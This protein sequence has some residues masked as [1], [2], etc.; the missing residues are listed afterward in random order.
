V[1]ANVAS[2]RLVFD[3]EKWIKLAQRSAE[4]A[5]LDSFY[6][7]Q[8]NQEGWAFFEANSSSYNI[9]LGASTDASGSLVNNSQIDVRLTRDGFEKKVMPTVEQLSKILP[10]LSLLQPE[11]QTLVDFFVR[12]LSR[13]GE[14]YA[15]AY[16]NFFSSL[17]LRILSRE[18]LIMYLRE[19]QRPGSAFTQNLVRIKENVIL[20]IPEGPNYQPFRERLDDFR[21][22]QT[23]MQEDKGTYPQLQRYMTII[24]DLSDKLAGNTKPKPSVAGGE[25]PETTSSG[26]R[27]L[28]SPMGRVTYDLKLAGDDNNLVM[29]QSWLREMMVP[30]QWKR[31]FLAPILKL[32]EYG[33]TEINSAVA[34]LWSKL[35]E[36][37]VEP[38]LGLFPFDLTM[39]R[40]EATPDMIGEVLHPLT[41]TFWR[42]FHNHFGGILDITEG[43]LAIR[44]DFRDFVAIPAKTQYQMDAVQKFTNT[45]WNKEGK[46]EPIKLQ[47]K[48][49]LLPA[50]PNREENPDEP[51]AELIYLRSGSASV[52]G[53]N[54]RGDWQELSEEWWNKGNATAGIQFQRG[55]ETIKLFASADVDGQSWALFRLINLATKDK[56]SRTFSWSVRLPQS[57]EKKYLCTYEFKNDPYQIF[58]NLSGTPESR[59]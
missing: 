2:S 10:K 3:S 1:T 38:L 4:K 36:Q 9:R 48:A 51:S 56:Q 8:S 34:S 46:V 27:N 44:Q 11:K 7:V 53:F 23:M 40:P 24:A 52:L 54:Q 42:E 13:Y 22:L 6:R 18:Q 31:L 47:V 26:M 32:E 41:G 29:A 39:G 58:K 43:R 33:Q 50:L 35:W 12:S 55:S 57:P 59:R 21:F 5:L 17:N 14:N 19:V 28:L 15:N 45:L 49:G 37:R 30:D 20:N 25:K 16:W